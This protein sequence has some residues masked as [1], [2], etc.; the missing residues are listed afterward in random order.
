MKLGIVGSRGF[1]DRTL[2]NNVFAHM[3]YDHIMSK[4]DEPLIIVSGGAAGPDSWAIQE[5]SDKYKLQTIVYPAEWDK[6]GKSAGYKRNQNIV[7]ESDM[8]LAF[9][10]GISKGTNHTIDLTK[11]ANKPITIYIRK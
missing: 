3:F 9:W 6:Y 10:D 5:A 2:F 1:T 4:K 11:A 8:I 7:N